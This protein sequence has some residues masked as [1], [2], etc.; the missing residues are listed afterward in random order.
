MPAG[1]NLYIMMDG[2]EEDWTTR[3]SM[4]RIFAEY[5]PGANYG[6]R[7]DEYSSRSSGVATE[8]CV[9]VEPVGPDY[10]GFEAWWRI[11]RVH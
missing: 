11:T 2:Y 8:E 9:E 10:F 5:G 6:D 1:E 3:Q 4:G 7:S